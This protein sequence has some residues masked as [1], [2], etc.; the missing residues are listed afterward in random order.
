MSWEPYFLIYRSKLKIYWCI[1]WE[2]QY[3]ISHRKAWRCKNWSCSS[4]LPIPPALNFFAEH[5]HS[6]VH[7][8]WSG[9]KRRKP[10][11]AHDSYDSGVQL[12]E[13]IHFLLLPTG[14]RMLQCWCFPWIS[15]RCMDSFL[16]R[17]LLEN[18][19]QKGSWM[20]CAS[21][22]CSKQGQLWSQTR[23]FKALSTLVLKNTEFSPE[24]RLS[25]F[26]G[27]AVVLLDCSLHENVSPYIQSEHLWF[28]FMSVGSYP[29][30]MHC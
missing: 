26:S 4:S 16:S 19:S 12:Y 25:S 17:E 14:V 5:A 6:V 28:P 18:S 9:A 7:S 24:Q 29:A 10:P 30:S 8:W 11:R 2:E 13:S 3:F 20:A 21:V 1:F 27:S 23:L 15:D 22:L